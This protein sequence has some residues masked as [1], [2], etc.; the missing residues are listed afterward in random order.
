MTKEARNPNPR[1]AIGSGNADFGISHSF[2]IFLALL[3]LWLP[4]A[5]SLE[6]AAPGTARFAV[7][8][9]WTSE[10]GLAGNSVFSLL[11]TQDG[12]LWVGTAYGLARFDGIHFETFDENNAPGLEGSQIIKLFED[13]RGNLWIGT[14]AAILVTDRAG[15]VSRVERTG[16]Q[17]GKLVTICEDRSGGIWLH[18]ANGQVRRFRDGNA[19]A[20]PDAKLEDCGRLMVDNS[21]IVWVWTRDGWLRSVGQVPPMTIPVG[22]LDFLLPSKAGGYW[23]LANN[24]VQRCRLDRVERDFGSYPWSAFTQVAAAV[25]DRA[26]NLVIGTY[27]DGVY[28]LDSAGKLIH[29]TNLPSAYIFSLC[30]DREGSLWV[31]TDN[32]GL[33]RVKQQ[34]FDVLDR[35]HPL[36]ITSVCEDKQAGLWFGINNGGVDYWHGNVLREYKGPEGLSDLYVRSV[37]ADGSGNVWVGTLGGGL[38][39]LRGENFQRIADWP[40]ISSM[41][42]DRLGQVWI[43]SGQ[44]LICWSP[45]KQ[46]TR[47][48][49]LCADAIQALADD[50]AGNLWI[51]TP[52]G[53]NVLRAG[54]FS[55]FHKTDGLPGENISALYVDAENVLWVGTSS[56][57]ARFDGTNWISYSTDTGLI[58]NRIGYLAEDAEHYLWLGSV[59]GLMRVNRKD[60]NDFARGVARSV[61]CRPYRVSDGLL[62]SECSAG[63]Q[64]A[65]CAA[66]DGT[67]WFPTTKGLAFVRPDQIRPN[68][69]QPPVRIESV[70]VQGHLQNPNRVRA[71]PPVAVTIPANK[72]GLE[73][74]YTSLNLSAPEKAR[75]KYRMEIEGHRRETNW[76]E[77]RNVRIAQFPTMPPGNHR[78]VVTA[79]NEDGVWNEAGS[80]L[81]VTVLPPFWRTTW[82]L[83]LA[84]LGLLGL[85]VGSVYYVSTQRLQR[86]VAAFRQQEAL[87]KERARIARDLHDQLGANLTQVA[88]LGEMVEVDKAAPEEVESHARQISSTARETTRSLDEIVWTVNPSNDTL[89]GLINYVCKYAQ[90]YLALAG[91][92][93]RLDVPP[94]LPATP[95]S[96]E[97][98]HNVFLAAKEAINNVVKHSQ[99]ASAWLRL[100]LEPHRFILEIEDNGLGIAAGNE[101]KG[102]SGLRNMRKRME[103]IGGEFEASPG[104]EGG[105]R[106]KLIAPLRRPDSTGA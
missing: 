61:P 16:G 11:Q 50:A 30:M 35:P 40:A 104:V 65:A 86:Q 22:Q 9:P 53:L 28:W 79:C 88:L 92:R 66:R 6:A 51:G 46:F 60:L 27:G 32:G 87:E 15:R 85:I 62:T 33:N 93:Y 55:A 10:Q 5:T 72:E 95:I 97:L 42:Q 90:E 48:D 101:Q 74:D 91:L 26:T 76:I 57:L 96:P 47:R 38:F 3:L 41:Y 63:S 105:T 82:F 13:S 52:G 73:I 4:A 68:T 81:A 56:G 36:P 98:R 21:G 100:H 75:F 49:G 45:R 58:S 103:D 20:A 14:D 69:N 44:G 34:V 94:Q 17:E 106:I 31:G 24:R 84:T 23:R 80:A 54:R 77:V 102:R 59:A 99:A 7:D 19:A 12:Y 25:E 1:V 39:Q 18:T 8:P 78:F 70:R 37:L 64:P 89:D 29:L 2:V 83:T 71:L 43:G 67:M